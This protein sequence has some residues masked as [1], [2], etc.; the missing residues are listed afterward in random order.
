MRVLAIQLT[1]NARPLLNTNF[2]RTDLPSHEAFS[3]RLVGDAVEVTHREK[4][5]FI[6]PMSS[7]SWYILD[8]QAEPV[9]VPKKRGRPRKARVSATA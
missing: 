9:T 4:G 6:I 1:V 2:I 8:P 5:V 3:M 7:V